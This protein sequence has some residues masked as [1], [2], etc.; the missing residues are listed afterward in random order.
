V[1]KPIYFRLRYFFFIFLRSQS[2]IEFRT[3]AFFFTIPISEPQS[4]FLGYIILKPFTTMLRIL[5]RP[6]NRSESL[7]IGLMNQNRRGLIPAV[8]LFTGGDW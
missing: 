2:I 1:E 4:R 6:E 7:G 3:W 5:S 8:G